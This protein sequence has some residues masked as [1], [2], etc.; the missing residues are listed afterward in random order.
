MFPTCV[1]NIAKNKQT[2]QRN[3]PKTH[4]LHN[5]A[6]RRQQNIEADQ[7]DAHTNAPTHKH[8]QT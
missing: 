4:L 1:S 8:V 7:T 2:E 3:E 6:H 5:Y